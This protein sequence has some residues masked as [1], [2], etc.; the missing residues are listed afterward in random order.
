MV[1]ARAP[2]VIGS[3]LVVLGLGY[4]IMGSSNPPQHPTRHGPF[5]AEAQTASEADVVRVNPKDYLGRWRKPRSE[6][7]E[8][9]LA[10]IRQLEAIGYV[11]GS[12]EA[13][14]ATG[15]TVHD[16]DKALNGYNFY[17]SGDRPGAVLMDMTGKVLHQWTFPFAKAF[18]KAS[19]LPIERAMAPIIGDE[20]SSWMRGTFWSSTGALGSSR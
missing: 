5:P 2:L 3:C 19:V 10:E 7:T 1:N 4:G 16:T 8:A 12:V 14:G 15:V 9:Q 18:P 20:P 11:S 13:S 17:T 6:L